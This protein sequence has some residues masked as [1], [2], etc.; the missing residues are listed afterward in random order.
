MTVKINEVARE[1]NPRRDR[2]LNPTLFPHPVTSYIFDTSAAVQRTILPS[3]G[4]ISGPSPPSTSDMDDSSTNRQEDP[5]A[6]SLQRGQVGMSLFTIDSE[7]GS[8]GH[9]NKPDEQD[10]R[11]SRWPL[12]VV[13][14]PESLFHFLVQE[15]E[16]TRVFLGLSSLDRDRSKG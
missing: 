5:P 15:L 14:M 1:Q 4:F 13:G 9:A 7:R 8:P 3:L 6:V 16:R 2:S 12:Y 10:D 11:G